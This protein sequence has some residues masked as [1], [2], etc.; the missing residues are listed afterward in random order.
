MRRQLYVMRKLVFLVAFFLTACVNTG[1]DRRA[2]LT[3]LIGQPETTVIQ[4]LG[5]PS[6]TFET[7]GHRFLAYDERRVD[8]IPSPP[9]FGG[10]YWGGGFG[11]G[12]GYGPFPPEIVER[13][14]ETTFDI[15]SGRVQSWNLRGSLCG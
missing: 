6:R 10:G 3:T 2:Y 9:L 1:A 11:F 12:Y 15:V 14:C 4:Q 13:G 8:V 5:V 7:D